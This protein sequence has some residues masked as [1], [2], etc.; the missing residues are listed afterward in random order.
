VNRN[1]PSGTVVHQT[2][3]ARYEEMRQAALE[4]SCTTG[5]GTAILLRRGMAAWMCAWSQ[6]AL[7]DAEQTDR[8]RAQMDVMPRSLA[9][10]VVVVLAEMVFQAN[11][12]A[13]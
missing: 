2:V 13:K 8:R 3:L 10:E 1:V 6:Y 12:E 4:G 11:G 9:P 5:H 7:S